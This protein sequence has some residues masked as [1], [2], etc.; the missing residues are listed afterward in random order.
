[1]LVSLSLRD[2]VL[3]ETLSLEVRGGFVVLTGE[4]GAGKSILVDALKLILGARSDSGVVRAGTRRADLS[5]VFSLG[6]RPRAWL[7][8]N[9][10]LSMDEPAVILRRTVDANGR[11][12]GWV[13]GVPVTAAQLRSLGE[14][15][16]EI[17]GQ[18]DFLSLLAPK[19]QLSL[20]DHYAGSTDVLAEVRSAHAL[21]SAKKRALEEARENEAKS[22][23][24]IALLTWQLR[25]LEALQPK[26]GEWERINEEHQRLSHFSVMDEGLREVLDGLTRGRRP[27]SDALSSVYGRLE[28]LTRYDEKLTSPLEMLGS[29]IDLVEDA[30]REIDSALDRLD[31]DPERF[32]KLDR[33]VSTYFNLA[34]RHH[35]APE[36]LFAL[37][38]KMRAELGALERG[39]D[40]KALENEVRSAKAAYEKAAAR[41]TQ[42]RREGALRFGEAVTRE[43][44]R[45]AM[46]GARL[47][48]EL[49]PADCSPDGM[50]TC[51]LLFAGHA[52]A[53]PAP[54]E[55]TASGGELSRL[56]LAVSTVTAAFS[57]VE[58][59]IFDEI[60]TG[61]GGETAQTV[62]R[63]LRDLSRHCG[64]VVSVT[65]SPQIA[66]LADTQFYVQ[67]ESDGHSTKSRTRELAPEERPAVIARMISGREEP[68]PRILSAAEELLGG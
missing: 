2:F 66:A 20:L 54:V 12:Q 56:S 34:H 55:R 62:G 67:K 33:R 28:T 58:T 27:V 37:Y 63:M 60:D 21:W 26:K 50:E 1:M 9:D 46:R 36:D 41:L 30:A 25:D 39:A 11:S 15:L 19:S 65:H 17:H 49:V 14:T 35:A 3:V 18:R 31:G 8:Q 29:A 23:E 32:E 6:D 44:Q 42:I 45:L 24:K 43:L 61:I 64:Q 13:N 57:P 53:D 52:G 47:E 48:A 40:L 5:A 10:L 68:S 51:R 4:T 16:I 22:A 38:G 7:A 59:M